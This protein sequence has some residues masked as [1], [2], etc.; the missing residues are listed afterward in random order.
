MAS[1]DA[2]AGRCVHLFSSPQ[3]PSAVRWSEENLLAVAAGHLV[4]IFNPASLSGSRGY[5]F[6]KSSPSLS[7]GSVSNADLEDSVL[8]PIRLSRENKV[9]VRSIDW[10]PQ[11]YAAEGG[12]L[13]AVCTTDSRIKLYQAPYAE[14]GSEWVEVSDLSERLHAEV[15]F[16]GDGLLREEK[17]SIAV[18]ASKKRGRAH[19]NIDPNQ[20][21][22]VHSHPVAENAPGVSMSPA[23]GEGSRKVAGKSSNH[24]DLVAD[25]VE[26]IYNRFVEKRA[27]VSMEELP[28][29]RGGE[30]LQG[31]DKTTLQEA[32]AE[33]VELHQEAIDAAKLSSKTLIILARKKIRSLIVTREPISQQ[34]GSGKTSVLRKNRRV[35]KDNANGVEH[36]DLEA[37][38]LQEI[39][40]SQKRLKLQ[41]RRAGE[42]KDLA[43]EVLCHISGAGESCLFPCGEEGEDTGQPAEGQQL[44]VFMEERLSSKQPA[45]GNV[46][47]AETTCLISES[48]NCHTLARR[49]STSEV[50][51]ETGVLGMEEVSLEIVAK[52]FVLGERAFSGVLDH[53]DE[54]QSGPGLSQFMVQQQS[55]SLENLSNSLDM[56]ALPVSI[57][58]KQL[59]AAAWAMRT[60]FL[61]SLT[62]AWSPN[63]TLQDGGEVHLAVGFK[64][65]YVSLW[66]ISMPPFTVG[67]RGTCP[68]IEW[69]GVWKAH[70]SWVTS[71]SWSLSGSYGGQSDKPPSSLVLLSGCTDGSARLWS[72]R[73]S[74]IEGEK[75]PKSVGPMALIKEVCPP[76]ELP[77]TC[78]ALHWKP[79]NMALLVAIG[80]G[81]GQ[82]LATELFP[83]FSSIVGEMEPVVKPFLAHNRVLT[84]LSWSSLSECLYSCS[85]GNELGCWRLENQ[86]LQR[87]PF[88]EGHKQVISTGMDRFMGLALSPNCLA[89]T[90]VSAGMRESVSSSDPNRAFKG[91]LHV[92]W[93]SEQQS[94]K[95]KPFIQESPGQESVLMAI[96]RLAGGQHSLVLWDVV[97]S[98]KGRTCYNLETVLE[99]LATASKFGLRGRLQWKPD[100]ELHMTPLES[101]T[102]ASLQLINVFLRKVA[103]VSLGETDVMGSPAEGNRN[104]EAE[105]KAALKMGEFELRQRFAMAALKQ[106][107]TVKGSLFGSMEE[108]GRDQEN[109]HLSAEQVGEVPGL[110]FSHWVLIDTQ[111]VWP[112]L[113]EEA[114]QILEQIG[115]SFPEVRT[116]REQC[117]F[118]GTAVPLEDPDFG[119]C[120]G[121]LKHKLPRCVF[122][123]RICGSPNLWHC[124]CCKRRALRPELPSTFRSSA[125]RSDILQ[126]VQPCVGVG[127]LAPPRT[128][129]CPFCGILMHQLLPSSC[130]TPV[131]T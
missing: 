15:E 125:T 42:N 34:L 127:H 10:S 85:Q 13:L 14:I 7:V 116:A 131:L 109:V 114:V 69:K 4:T 24:N 91:A 108:E 113:R 21:P 32:L 103:M 128:P 38:E 122:T 3:F 53:S 112:S 56:P 11:G 9:A 119:Q 29:Y 107:G 8:L 115:E 30:H 117:P 61:S 90:T 66:K 106:L 76:D 83:P 48:D 121:I 99:T 67:V 104:C 101:G 5:I 72:P 62:L 126:G 82:L 118:C 50:L 33:V 105:L 95:D 75:C 87:K 124:S 46:M 97:E 22:E 94:G 54:G 111:V 129:C 20:R 25:L 28:V 120:E 92:H 51:C 27:R 65:G 43:S 130:L 45:P 88:P 79:H 2:A 73:L 100:E 89:L 23:L 35:H 98:L 81:G 74:E 1:A 68:A 58:P 12:C 86:T 77:V 78:S 63:C 84:G 55:L 16:L 96:Q 17:S 59:S 19:E 26:D 52:D 36:S 47:A 80:K 44:A 57:K 41:G 110:L 123:L 49:G 6:C 93:L 40:N 70:E 18:V 31:L 60:D 37:N 64:S 102:C 71:L 39:G